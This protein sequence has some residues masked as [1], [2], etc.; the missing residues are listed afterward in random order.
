MLLLPPFLLPFMPLLRSFLVEATSQ[1]SRDDRA[2]RVWQVILASLTSGTCNTASGHCS[3]RA[4][5][6]LA[7]CL[8]NPSCAA[9]PPQVLEHAPALVPFADRARLFQNMV[10][11]ERR[12][13]Y[14]SSPPLSPAAQP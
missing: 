10:A 12:A 14:T 11:E 13:S 1:R 7:L 4:S 5:R 8:S 3:V 2:S 6:T 9:P